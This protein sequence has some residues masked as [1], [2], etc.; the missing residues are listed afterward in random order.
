LAPFK[1]QRFAAN[2]KIRQQWGEILATLDC[3]AAHGGMTDFRETSVGLETVFSFDKAFFF[4][5]TSGS[6]KVGGC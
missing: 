5:L 3:P 6:V 2:R 1:G 4:V